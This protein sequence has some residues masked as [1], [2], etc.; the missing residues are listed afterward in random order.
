[1]SWNSPTVS[2]SVSSGLRAATV[3]QERVPNA[4]LPAR[5][6]INPFPL[7][8]LPTSPPTVKQRVPWWFSFDEDPSQ[9]GHQEQDEGSN[10]NNGPGTVRSKAGRWSLITINT[11]VPGISWLLKALA[12]V[13][14][15]APGSQPQL[16]HRKVAALCPQHAGLSGSQPH[17]THGPETQ[18]PPSFP[19]VSL[20]WLQLS[21]PCP[22]F[23]PTLYPGS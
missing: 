17:N 16:G 8:N 22:P 14:Q 12:P 4:R 18:V 9:K 15:K 5:V 20:V 19:P 1:M 10:P 7:R 3:Q 6:D 21:C 11:T 23:S 13:L 2:V